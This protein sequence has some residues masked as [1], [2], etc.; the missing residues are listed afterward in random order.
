MSLSVD[1]GARGEVE[2]VLKACPLN[3]FFGKSGI[4]GAF[5]TNY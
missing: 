1:T 2:G 5:M 3:F 4:S